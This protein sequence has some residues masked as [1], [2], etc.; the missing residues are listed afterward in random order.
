MIKNK[1]LFIISLGFNILFIGLLCAFIMR[2]GGVS[3]ITSKLAF[4]NSKPSQTAVAKP[5]RPSYQTSHYYTKVRNFRQFPSSEK[6][7]FL[8]GDSLTDYGEWAEL[9][10]NCHVKNR[11][12]S[13]DTTEGVLNRIDEI[14][15]AKPQKI[16]IMIGVNDVWNEKRTTEQIIK[17]YTQ[18]LETFKSQIPQT[19][20]YI[21]SLL[22][23]N[24]KAYSP[25]IDNQD[26]MAVNRRL[27]ELATQFD[28]QY[29]NLYPRFADDSNQLKPE[30]TN[31]GVHLNGKAYLL[32]AEMITPLVNSLQK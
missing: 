21:Q 27:Q 28:Y 23:V 10:D 7:I 17:N 31:D 24:N 29:L 18:I 12:I 1:P 30:Y 5:R 4:L 14:I 11:G 19:Q 25:D 8:V 26:L 2:K 9:L 20:V 13:G 16:F 32:W 22:P 15:N 3:Y 6:D